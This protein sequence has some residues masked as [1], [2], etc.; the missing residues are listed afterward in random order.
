MVLFDAP[1]FV[2]EDYEREGKA[3]PFN[4]WKPKIGHSFEFIR[5]IHDGIVCFQV[6]HRVL[7]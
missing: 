4:E 1:G 7:A 2:R 3:K 5:K 6:L